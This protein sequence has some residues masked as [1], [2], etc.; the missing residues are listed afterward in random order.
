MGQAVTFSAQ[1]SVPNEAGGN[2]TPPSGQV[3]FLEDG[4]VVASSTIDSTGKATFT[5]SSLA[6]GGHAIMAVYQGDSNFGTS[7]SSI[8]AEH[9]IKATPGTAQGSGSIKNGTGSFSFTATAAYGATNF[10][11]TAG[12]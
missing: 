8:L 1:V 6:L 10:S 5:T 4:V 2:V 9:V 7:T 3:S 11:V 12:T